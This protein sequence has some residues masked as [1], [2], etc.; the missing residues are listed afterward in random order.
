MP[1]AYSALLIVG[2]AFGLYV[3]TAGPSLV[4]YRD[5]GEMATSVPML[6]ILHP[7]SYPLYS[8]AGFVFSQLPLGNPAYRLNVFS[9]LAMACAGGLLW[10]LFLQMEGKW[11]ALGTVLLGALSYHFWWHSVVS[12]MYALNVL[13]LAALL[14]AYGRR[15]FLLV[16]VSLRCGTGQSRGFGVD[17]AGICIG[18]PFR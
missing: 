17:A 12:E 3:S 18:L 11:A 8:I 10:L 4:P 7:T 14:W 13:F 16:G 6:G 9:A 1:R 15:M 5:A 2:L